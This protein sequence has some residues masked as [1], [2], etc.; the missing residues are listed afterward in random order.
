VLNATMVSVAAIGRAY[1][2]LASITRKSGVKQV[3]RLLGNGGI[4][5]DLVMQKW[6]RFVVGATPKLVIAIDWT[7]FDDHDHTTLCASLMTTHG[8]A[9]PLLWHTVQKSKLKG[10]RTK[11]ELDLIVRLQAFLPDGVGVEVLGDRAF[12]YQELYALLEKYGWDLLGESFSLVDLVL[13]STVHYGA[14]FGV[15]PQDK[16]RVT[17]WLSAFRERKA[18]WAA[19]PT[20]DSVAIL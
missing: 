14:L 18:A 8:R 11:H 2:E 6:I 12:G 7:D 3:D 19:A 5:L 1:S 4:K 10:K 9:T 15:L 17:G 16:P 20:V 13:A